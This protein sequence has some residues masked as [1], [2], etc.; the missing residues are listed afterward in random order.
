MYED[1]LIPFGR[2]YANPLY[3]DGFAPSN[4]TGS[5]DSKDLYI[6]V[7]NGIQVNGISLDFGTL[8]MVKKVVSNC[9]PLLSVIT[10]TA[11]AFGNGNWCIKRI[12]DNTDVSNENNKNKK[13]V[14]ILRKPNP[15]QSYQDLLSD[16]ARYIRMYGGAYFFAAVPTGFKDI[17]DARAL[18]VF[19]PREVT[20]VYKERNIFLEQDLDMV[21]E[22]YEITAK[23]GGKNISFKA[24]PKHVVAVYDTAEETIL[25]SGVTKAERVVSLKY[26]I[27][28]IMQAQEAIYSL[29]ADRGAQ[30]ILANT[31]KDGLG[32]VQMDPN[33]KTRVEDSLR[34]KYGMMRDQQKIIV[35]DA[36]LSYTA[37]GFNVKDL[38]LHEGVRENVMTLCDT[39]SFPFDLLASEKGKTAADKT[40]SM[41]SLYQDNIIPLANNISAKLTLWFG[42][43]LNENVIQIDYSHLQIFQSG[44]V[45]KNNALRQLMQACH[46]AY[47]NDAITREE[48]RKYIG[49]AAE[50]PEKGTLRSKTGAADTRRDV[51]ITQS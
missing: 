42:L 38:M 19:S 23:R 32:Y 36:P 31:A 20:V 3:G 46:I 51:R 45:E 37:I 49:L 44:N 41:I 4:V 39:F 18:W 33:E 43:E 30:G 29:S 27:R 10:K 47:A 48:F 1:S 5:L 14:A 12:S 16:A 7:S 17:Q 6:K 22:R 26:E 40:L 9:A 25:D 24:E 8:E 28:N 13:I 50:I 11:E 35:T 2:G 21:I 34:T 15:L